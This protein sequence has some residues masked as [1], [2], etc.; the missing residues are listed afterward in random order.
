ML[1]Q[2][3]MEDTMIMAH[4]N[5]MANLDKSLDI[6]EA[7][8]KEAREMSHICNDEWCNVTE[9]AI[10]DMHKSIYA[11]SEPRWLPEEDSR[12]LKSLRTRV[13]DLYRV[14]AHVKEGR[15]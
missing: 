5:F 6:L 11:I 8:L 10:D 2:K 14:F 9:S 3:D 1:K 13:R 7:E 4:Q 15:A 12:K